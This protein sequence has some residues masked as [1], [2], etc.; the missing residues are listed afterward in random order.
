MKKIL[1]IAT[2]AALLSASCKKDKTPAEKVFKGPVTSFQHGKA[3]TSYETDATDKP[4]RIV[5]AMDDAALASLDRNPPGTGPHHHENMV[6]LKFHP[7]A[8][9][10]PFTHVGLDWNPAGHEPAPIYGKPH[11]DFHFYMISEAD[12]LAIPPYELDSLRFKNAPAAGFLPPAYINP[13]GGVPQMG[14]HWVDATSPELN[15][16]PFTQTFIYGSYNGQV[17]FYEPMITEQFLLANA[18]FERAIPQPAKFRQAGYY[19]TKM[20]VS[21]QNGATEIALEDFVYR[22]TQ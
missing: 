10:T 14:A 18:F 17:N 8:A 5:I 2:F 1:L 9:A 16:H 6:S 7:K 3:W 12:R 19:P 15:G 13:G 20:R 22:N 11:F 21:R 4:L